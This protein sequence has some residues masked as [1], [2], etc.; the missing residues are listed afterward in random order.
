MRDPSSGSPWPR[1]ASR[2][3]AATGI[4]SAREWFVCCVCVCVCVCVSSPTPSYRLLFNENHTHAQ[5][6][7][8]NT[9]ELFIIHPPHTLQI[10]EDTSPLTHTHTHT[11]SLTHT[12]THTHTHTPQ[13]TERRHIEVEE[14]PSE[15]RQGNA[16]GKKMLE[17]LHSDEV[18]KLVEAGRRLVWCVCV[19]VCVCEETTEAA[20]DW[21]VGACKWR[22]SSRQVEDWYGAYVSV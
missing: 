11:H 2:R 17:S 15:P 10:T 5:K 12:H 20:E 14:G 21:F 4:Q 22:S 7:Q 18:E 9:L 13:I 19:C 8:F 3:T 16:V 6:M 1:P